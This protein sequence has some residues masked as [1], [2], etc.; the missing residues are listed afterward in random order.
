MT[1]C[2]CASLP[3]I[4]H[5]PMGDHQGHDERFLATVQELT[6]P[7]DPQWWR[8][9]GQCRA[10]TQYWLVAQEERIFD[11]HLLA[12]INEA[13]AARILTANAWPERFATYEDVLRIAR[14]LATP[15]CFL[16]PMADSLIS[17]IK[18]LRRDRPDIRV[19]EVAELL[20]LAD[21]YARRL[22][23]RI[24]R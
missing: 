3:D 5:I 24:K 12:R 1:D 7:G 22:I 6:S 13:E 21:D 8:Y 18:D 15:C 9:L 2:L 23:A 14:S 17:T 11:E 4:A 20:G 19:E 16:E 10:C